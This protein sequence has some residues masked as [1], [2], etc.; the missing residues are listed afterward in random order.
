MKTATLVGYHGRKN[1]GDDIF[2]EIVIRWLSTVLNV[3]KCHITAEKDLLEP[4]IS[5]VAIHTFSS[6]IKRISRLLWLS[7]FLKAMRS[8]Y[9]IFSAGSI[10]TILPFFLLYLVIWQLKLIR[11]DTLKIMAIGVSIG[12]FRNNFD[13]Y[14]CFKTL[15][16]MDHILLRDL[17]SKKVLDAADVNL[18]CDLSYDL[19]LCWHRMFVVPYKKKKLGLIGIAVTSR[20]FGSCQD[21]KHSHN[22]NA[23]I[24]ATED[25]MNQNA[26]ARI[27]ILCVCSDEVDG[28]LA[29]CNH[30]NSRLLKWG[31]RVEVV[32]Y[33]GKDIDI[34]LPA[35]YECSLMIA[36]RMH[37][38]I[39]AMCAS[40]PLYQISYAE[41]ITSF[42]EHCE[43]SS[44]FLYSHD[45]MTR[46][47]L[48]NFLHQ[49]LLNNLD[50]FA[51]EQSTSLRKKGDI[52]YNDLLMLV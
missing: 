38:G 3:N 50:S 1:F 22:C 27:R 8:D 5:N 46:E 34:F 2:R 52:I 17:K 4:I 9:L 14:W 25:A 33:N 10:F 18:S 16:L 36:S 19:A 31:S 40:I 35:I 32:I 44:A 51:V 26:Y 29:L 23:I 45:Q 43:L 15:S 7:I 11:G 28:D 12:P 47:S 42:F 13:R 37:A 24:E 39:M 6:P 48:K 20:G 30:I 21:G 49:G 41:K